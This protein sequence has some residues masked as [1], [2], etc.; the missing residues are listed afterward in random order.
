M[1]FEKIKYA[2]CDT[3]K[4]YINITSCKNIQMFIDAVDG[5]YTIRQGA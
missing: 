1:L 4:I 3:H 2:D 5:T